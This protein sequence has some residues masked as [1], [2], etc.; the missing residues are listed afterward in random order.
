MS[1]LLAALFMVWGIAACDGGGKEDTGEQPLNP[2]DDDDKDG[3]LNAD[4]CD[5][6]EPAAH[7]GATEVCDGIDNNCDAVIDEQFDID[8]DGF[9]ADDAGCRAMGV[10]IDCD[11][12]DP[13][14][15]PGAVESCDDEID[16]DCSGVAGD[17]PD[18]DNDGSSGCDDCDDSDPVVFP[19]QAEAC[20][21]IDNDCNGIVD[22]GWDEDGDGRS[23]CEGDCDDGDPANSDHL[24][25]VCD[26]RDN[27]CDN[28]VDEGFDADGDGVIACMG[29]CDDTDPL[30]HNRMPEICD[31]GKDTDCDGVINDTADLDADGFDLCTDLD[32]DDR[33]PAVFPGATEIC[34]GVDNE[35]NA[36]VDEL[37]ECSGC[38][39]DGGYWLCTTPR[40]WSAAD[41]SCAGFGTSLAVITSDA[42][43]TMLTTLGSTYFGIDR[44]W[45]GLSDLVT[46]GMFEWVDG[47]A[48]GYTAWSVGEPNGA[49]AN[50]C[51]SIKGGTTTWGD[52]T[53]SG[54][55]GFVCE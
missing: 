37:P 20:D 25:E 28:V 13:A 42:E 53:C 41:A 10:E 1:R 38:T 23:S 43:N 15:N 3:S 33:N 45:V 16:N 17:G 54:A 22:D 7:P 18:A 27:N 51:V 19:G 50:D 21:A 40:T 4:D 26:Q 9:L 36:I 5:P 11:D 12:L 30:V 52:A 29:D 55:Q 32:C 14:V 46:E 35:C 39:Q 49:Q 8:G 24:P 48:L 44:Y 2:A 34:D 31:G 47:T 6:L